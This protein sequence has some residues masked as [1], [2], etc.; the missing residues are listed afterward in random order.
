MS[1]DRL[2]RV[3]QADGSGHQL[4]A[5]TW[6]T[7]FVWRRGA[8]IIDDPVLAKPFAPAIEPLAWVYS[9][10]AQQP[11]SGVARG[12]LLWTNGTV[13]LPLGLRRWHTGGPSKYDLALALLSYARNRLRC[14]PESVLFE[15]C[16]PAKRLLTRMRDY[17]WDFGGRVQKHR[18]F[19]GHA[20]RPQ[21]RPP[22]WTAM[23]RL[24]GGRK[25]RLVRYGKKD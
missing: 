12:L 18:C 10:Q 24:R 3:L 9:S 2:P 13:R 1:H 5:L 16:Y 17:G 22:Y 25:V 21:R 15:A 7:L 14:R 8:R 4:L 20:V 11:V 19:N 6:R 23:G